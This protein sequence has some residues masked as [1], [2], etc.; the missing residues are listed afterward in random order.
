MNGLISLAQKNGGDI[1]EG[2]STKYAAASR[3]GRRGTL[4]PVNSEQSA[5][6]MSTEAIQEKVRPLFEDLRKETADK[7]LEQTQFKIDSMQ[8]KGLLDTLKGRV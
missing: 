4:S 1:L 8:N 2:L 7:Y 6:N 3:A 5:G